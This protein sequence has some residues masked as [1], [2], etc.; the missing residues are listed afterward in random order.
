MARPSL[1]VV[2]VSDALK[3]FSSPWLSVNKCQDSMKSL[4]TPSWSVTS[5]SEKIFIATLLWAVEQL[6]SP[7]SPNVLARKLLPSLPQPWKSR[8]WHQLSASSWCGSEDQ[9]SVHSQPSKLCGSPKPNFRRLAQPS[10]TENA[11]DHSY[12]INIYLLLSINLS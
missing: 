7:V 2:N 11:S 8:S 6:C 12:H 10:F 4:I 9:F 3:L 1:S 5:I